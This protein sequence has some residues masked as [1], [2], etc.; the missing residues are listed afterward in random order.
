MVLKCKMNLFKLYFEL[1]SE[2]RRYKIRFLASG[3]PRFRKSFFTREMPSEIL[4]FRNRSQS[5]DKSR[6]ALCTFCDDEYIYPRL[7]KL[8]KD[9]PIYKEY[10]AVV[11][12]DLSPRVEWKT[13][14]QRFNICLNQ[15]ASIYLALNGIKLIG[16]FRTGD[17]TTYET[18]YSYPEN[19]PFFV[20]TLG[21]SRKN[22]ESDA[23]GF[24]QKILIGAPKECWL[25]GCEDKLVTRILKDY[26]ISYKVFKDYRTRSFSK[27]Q[28]VGDVR[29]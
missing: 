8:K 23:Y 14:Q 2:L 10:L 16:N 27:K 9:I 20:G 5:Q 21:C 19:I 4:P 26:K 24:E 29:Y 7:N 28:E 6:T 1:Y 13:E 11:F 12:F 22:D 15:M 18:L 17:H 3:F 25:Y